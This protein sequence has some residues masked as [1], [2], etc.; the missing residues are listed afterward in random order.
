MVATDIPMI[1]GGNSEPAYYLTI[2][3]LPPEIAATKNKRS[4]FLIQQFMQEVLQITPQR[5]VVRYDSVAE[6]NLATNGVTA[7]QEIEQLERQSHDEDLTSRT[8]SRLEHR[9]SKRSSLTNPIKR[10]KTPTPQTRSATPSV[11]PS[12]SQDSRASKPTSTGFT[13]KWK[14]KHRKSIFQ[15]FKRKSVEALQE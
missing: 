7:L 14:M 11:L 3:A 10:G 15:L 8:L 13:G 1:M 12:E 4:A 9:R 2:T 5:G 6:D